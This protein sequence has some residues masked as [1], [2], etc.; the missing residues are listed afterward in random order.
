MKSKFILLFKN[1][2]RSLFWPLEKQAKYAGVQMGI[3][4]IIYSRFWSSEP[5]LISI[6]NHCQFTGG[7]KVFTHGG[8]QAVRE[9]YP[10][11]DFFGKVVFGDYVY[12]GENSLIMPGVSIGSRVIVAAGSVVTK[13]VPSGVV[14]GGNPAKIICTIQDFID[15]NLKYNLNSKE[16]SPEEKR[17]FLLS[18]DDDCFIKKRFLK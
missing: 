13:S 16:L 18:I 10:D 7:C 2:Y 6:G 17:K 14:I 4:N 3:G 15:R 12:V 11:F 1:A 5:Y 8:A 9:S